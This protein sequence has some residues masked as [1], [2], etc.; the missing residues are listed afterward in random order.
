LE[1]KRDLV[2]T[3]AKLMSQRS[4]W[5]YLIALLLLAA[6]G[7]WSA[8]TGL[9]PDIQSGDAKD[10]Y[11]PGRAFS[12]SILKSGALPAWNPYIYGGYPQIADVQTG[13]F[14]PPNLILFLLFK[15]A[16]AFN[17]AIVF[18]VLLIAFFTSRF[19]RLFVSSRNAVW[20]G[21]AT[22]ALAGILSNNAV[23]L[24][25]PDAAAWI[26]A[27]FWCVEQWIR[28][29]R[30]KY[31]AWGGI[32]LAMQLLAGW[33]QMVLLTVIYLGV[34][35]LLASHRSSDR[36]R[37]WSGILLMGL[38]SAGL[39]MAQLLPTLQ[40]KEQSVIHHLSYPEFI[41]GSVAPQLML[42]MFFPF[43]VGA[44]YGD[45]HAFHKVAFY[46][47]VSHQVNVYYVG[48]LPLMLA[49][50]AIP[51]W[52]R[53]RYVRYGLASALLSFPLM[54]GGYT[55][56][57]R[58]LYQIPVYNFFHD[59]RINL[60][61]FDF[62]IAI[63]AAYASDKVHLADLSDTTRRR[64]SWLVP[65]ATIATAALLLVHARA[66]LRSMNPNVGAMPE[67]WLVKLHQTMRFGNPD[68]I[69]PVALLLLGGA[70]FCL[71]MRQ[72]ARR[73]IAVLGVAFAI[74]D[75]CYFG[76]AGQWFSTPATPSH[77][78][79]AALQ[80]MREDA[81]TKPFRSLSM[82]K[83]YYPAISPNL[84]TLYDHSDILGLGPFLSRY[85]AALLDATNTAELT[86]ARQL[87]VNN[88]VLSLLNTRFLEVERY[89]LAEF[90][91]YLGPLPQS[92]G[93]NGVLQHDQQ[94]PAQPANLVKDLQWSLPA[95]SPNDRSATFVRSSGGGIFGITQ[96]QVHLRPSTLY[97]LNCQVRFVRPEDPD[98]LGVG[99]Q[100][101]DS[102]QYYSVGS[103]MF[104]GSREFQPYTRLYWTGDKPEE[105]FL[106]FITKSTAGVELKEITL[107]EVGTQPFIG[108]P[109]RLAGKFG[110]LYVVENMNVNPR[111][112]FV[113]SVQPVSSFS[114]ARSVLW[115]TI[116]RFDS[117]HQAL[118]EA[119]AD[120]LPA[121][122]SNGTVER[123]SYRPN[124]ADLDVT[125]EAACYLVLCDT[126]YPGWLATVDGQKTAIY[127]TDAMVRGII[128]PQGRHHI[129]FAYHPRSLRLGL[130]G[131]FA[132]LVLAAFFLFRSRAEH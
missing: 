23:T 82:V 52:R 21:S 25:I 20:L 50:A 71:W 9:I 127:R 104:N 8:H 44:G 122:I 10:Y 117:R 61:F 81:A 31:P 112:F 101:Q 105:P 24:T 40:L 87:L 115:R 60:V 42:L 47:P 74:A 124:H 1:Q 73:G 65:A 57:G 131:S 30:W 18:N 27:T 91:R 79:I 120:E 95:N 41:F 4:G 5:P 129:Q 113:S 88:T 116:D 36:M 48:I 13:F 14:Y 7:T 86:Q 26:P 98:D 15:P 69:V 85:H 67:G 77:E 132:T 32:C 123:L 83:W 108:L 97:E 6:V 35:L 94:S 84:N 33:P 45:L 51:L 43:L 96:V 89:E 121:T 38:I 28:T 56:M 17:L 80:M 54:W 53:S 126:Y 128:V 46:G 100:T 64:L 19:L 49:L 118:A 106:K 2:F 68:M 78:E 58:L 114:A 119:P 63:L 110:G 76:V 34:Y 109:Y 3:M 92:P 37:F 107:Q 12:A 103:W 22:F 62:A 55:P 125:C 11:L 39:G 59:H 111:A 102:S 93:P 75:L 70:L 130:L 99:F 16:V 90:Q 66:L 72:P 29:Q